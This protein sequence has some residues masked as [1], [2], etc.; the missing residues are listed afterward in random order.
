LLPITFER[1]LDKVLEAF[2]PDRL[3]G[4]LSLEGFFF[5][6]GMACQNRLKGVKLFPGK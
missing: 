3:F 2:L 6:S 4:I 1:A 5:L